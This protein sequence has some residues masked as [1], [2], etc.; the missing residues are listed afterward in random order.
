MITG[1]AQSLLFWYF[2]GMR[3]L[4]VGKNKLYEHW[5]KKGYW[6]Y[7][8]NEISTAS[9]LML[10][11]DAFVEYRIQ[12]LPTKLVLWKRHFL[13]NLCEKIANRYVKTQTGSISKKNWKKHIWW[14][15]KAHRFKY[16]Y[17]DRS[18]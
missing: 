5:K 15:K 13:A 11:I 17:V 10:P 12:T 7:P 1:F 18:N 4:A 9:L 16:P 3:L 6:L 8:I 14:S 2:R